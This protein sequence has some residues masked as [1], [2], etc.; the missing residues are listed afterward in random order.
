[1][2]YPIQKN[3]S[4][5]LLG[6]TNEQEMEFQPI[7]MSGKMNR[8]MLEGFAIH[9]NPSRQ[10]YIRKRKLPEY[11]RPKQAEMTLYLPWD[12]PNVEN[13]GFWFLPTHLSTW[14]VTWVEADQ[15]EEA[16]WL[17]HTCGAVT[18]YV[19]GR[20]VTDFAP[21]TRNTIQAKEVRVSL[22]KGRNEVCAYF[23]DIAERDT[24]YLFRLDYL[25]KQSLSIEL[26][27]AQGENIVKLEEAMQNAYLERDTSEDGSL[28]LAICNPLSEKI[29]YQMAVHPYDI[30]G[31]DKIC[32]WSGIFSE[33]DQKIRYNGEAGSLPIGFCSVKL[34]LTYAGQILTRGYSLQSYHKAGQAKAGEDITRRRQRALEFIGKYGNNDIFRAI[35]LGKEKN[36]I[37]LAKT[38]IKH[39][40]NKIQSRHDCS[41][42]YLVGLIYLW[43]EYQTADLWTEEEKRLI[44]AV[45][46]G[47]RYWM[48]EPGN[49]VMWFFSENHAL[50]FHVCQLLAGET[51][52]QEI[53]FNSGLTGKEHQELAG[54]RLDEWFESFFA[55]GI[56]EWN[57]SAYLPVDALGFLG[58]YLMTENNKYKK[59]AK[60]GLDALFLDM[61]IFGKDGVLSCTFGRSY[62]KELKGNYI[63]GTSMMMA[64]AWGEGYYNQSG[65]AGVF[66]AL[67]DYEPPHYLRY[68]QIPAGNGLVFQR[69]Q[70]FQN[71]V[72]LSA[73]KTGEYILSSAY[74][75]RPGTPGYQQHVIHAYFKPTAMVWINH[76]GERHLHG[77]GRPSFWAGNGRLPRV[78][79]YR[80]LAVAIYRLPE[81][82]EI[83]YTH[84]YFPVTEFDEIYAKGNWF[85]GKSGDAYVGIYADGGLELRMNGPNKER[86]LIS[87]G[88]ENLW[89]LRVGNQVEY[90][91]FDDFI[92]KNEYQVQKEGDRYG[93]RDRNYG[94]FT[95]G[96]TGGFI[97]NGKE[98]L[99]QTEDRMIDT[100][101]WQEDI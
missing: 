98:I 49:D 77:S 57:S 101:K 47:F 76:P 93:F 37:P 2:R 5:W 62:E 29:E 9:E 12:N 13:S 66:L 87:K 36:N 28:E 89:L 34:S 14:A 52:P 8:W 3:I 60:K 59:L 72:R 78:W 46:L 16:T 80:G 54:K 68:R 15:A 61:A 33:H 48:E 50:L 99:F 67:S 17:L 26:P 6:K 81:N 69:E 58:L 25:G 30:L 94:D 1:M 55:E 83:D 56:T 22:S 82:D 88:R 92:R 32:R 40:A 71:Y 43:R 64:L 27:I 53:F 18:L 63:A 65:M 74:D 24:Q 96:W 44:K 39:F 38:I 97:R 84:A 20:L 7:T 95:V 31:D 85:Y 41:D 75:F 11:Q 35:A 70:G 86:E 73:F 91:D 90:R 100:D 23:E 4:H 51:F 19:N 45:I 21:F 79:Q 10:E 42:F